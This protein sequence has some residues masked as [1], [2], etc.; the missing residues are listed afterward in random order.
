MHKELL[1]N[2]K[3]LHL[4]RTQSKNNKVLLPDKVHKQNLPPYQHKVCAPICNVTHI[5][6]TLL[7]CGLQIND[8]HR[9]HNQHL[10]PHPRQL[11]RQR[12]EQLVLCTNLMA[13]QTELDPCKLVSSVFLKDQEEHSTQAARFWI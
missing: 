4:Q 1:Q 8:Q 13:C 7:H 5:V 11:N 6:S 12:E 2:F 10:V 3:K 9:T